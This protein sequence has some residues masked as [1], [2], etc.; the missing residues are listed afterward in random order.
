[1]RRGRW[2][3][4]KTLYALLAAII[5]LSLVISVYAFTGLQNHLTPM[6]ISSGTTTQTL[7]WD[8]ATSQNMTGPNASA[9]SY[10]S[11]SSSNAN[12]TQS[13][14]S[15][16]RVSLFISNYYESVNHQDNGYGKIIVYGNVRSPF[17]PT[18]LVVNMVYLTASSQVF[19]D[20][21][22]LIPF[23]ASNV[24][25]P[26]NSSNA[27][28]SLNPQVFFRLE[29]YS[30]NAALPYEFQAA[31]YIGFLIHMLHRPF[32]I[33]FQFSGVLEGHYMSPVNATVVVHD[34]IIPS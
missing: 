17:H 31:A 29:N 16:I 19:P 32:T 18:F 25:Y 30:A 4:R 5:A 10:F 20:G 8:N 22:V 1:M 2:T 27:P 34:Q 12:I 7:V 14:N 33:S 9:T 11:V 13:S 21:Y 23:G 28:N 24:S 15:S 6:K 3:R 26:Q